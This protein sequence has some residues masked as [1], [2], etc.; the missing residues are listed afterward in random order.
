LARL[1][2]LGDLIRCASYAWLAK[3]WN[4]GTRLLFIRHATRCCYCY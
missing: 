2:S 1:I 3:S 4:I